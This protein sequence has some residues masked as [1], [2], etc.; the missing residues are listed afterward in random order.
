LPRRSAWR[1]GHGEASAAFE[2]ASVRLAELGRDRTA[3]AGTLYNNWALSLDTLGRTAD[4][5]RIF[6]QAIELSRADPTD[7]TVSPML[8][9]NYSRTLRDLGRLEESAANAE[10]GYAKAKAV[11]TKWS[12]I[13]HCCREARR[14]VCNTTS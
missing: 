13:S 3:T 1:G 6:R 12:S 5:E 4:A 10:R 11:G 8:L 2:Q 14:I 9:V 7:E